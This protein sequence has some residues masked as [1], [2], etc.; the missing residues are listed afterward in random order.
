[1]LNQ[2]QIHRGN[3]LCCADAHFANLKENGLPKFD[4]GMCREISRSN[5]LNHRALVPPMRS[6][7]RVILPIVSIDIQKF[8]VCSS[9]VPSL[10]VMSGA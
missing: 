1:M 2:Y 5:P 8:T 6:R 4:V 7:L 9:Q 3:E 10:L